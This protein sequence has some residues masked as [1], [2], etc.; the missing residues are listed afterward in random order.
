MKDAP[1]QSQMPNLGADYAKFCRILDMAEQRFTHGD[2]E[3]SVALAQIAARLAYPANVGLFASPRLEQLLVA[4]GKSL[5]VSPKSGAH[6]T[7]ARLGR[8]LHVMS[9]ARPVGGDTRFVWRWIKEDREN[10]HSVAVTTQADINGTYGIP[11][12]LKESV[13]RSGGFLH[14]LH[15]PTSRPLEQAL[16][17]RKLCQDADIVV[18]HLFPYDVIPIL[19]LCAGCDGV[20]T[21]FVDH[22][23]HTFWLGA[24][25][26]H[27]IVHLRTQPQRFLQRS[28]RLRSGHHPLLPIP[29]AYSAPQTTRAE[30][31]AALGYDRDAVIL[32]TIASPFKYSS[33]A[34]QGLLELVIPVLCEMRQAV[35]LAVGPSPEGD[36]REASIR[37]D[38]RVVALGAR[39]DNALLYAAAD[40]YLDSVPFSSITSLLEAGS[41]GV[42]L[43]GLSPP[44]A[45][46]CLLGPGAPGLNGTMEIGADAASYQGLL[47]R[48]IADEDFRLET[49]R[50]VRLQILARHTGPGWRA[51]VKGV[52]AH[53]SRTGPRGCLEEGSDAFAAGSLN[54]AL[55][56]LY[57]QS[58]G[59]HFMRQ[60]LWRFLQP[61]PYRTRV[62]IVWELYRTGFGISIPNLLPASL[63]VG[64]RS[65]ARL[66]HRLKAV[67]AQRRGIQPSQPC[68]RA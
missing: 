43:L 37:T 35:L 47:R 60:L 54:L 68:H 44:D 17:L 22:S 66:A 5:T 65:C 67:L 16:E 64:A 53:L 11:H 13:E 50:R 33:P 34:R 30:A 45:D 62:A 57:E 4:I 15:V 1:K 51:A 23:D 28:R 6:A 12:Q 49:G 20:R 36:W 8:I 9:Y 56:Q 61:L 26:A 3:S 42:P 18:L 58:R 10:T 52:Y 29:L 14:V 48:L 31:K 63:N 40:V 2:A 59:R 19:A 21:I 25:V 46:L 39:Y 24:S 41:L 27:S 55:V 7:T 32:L 38:G